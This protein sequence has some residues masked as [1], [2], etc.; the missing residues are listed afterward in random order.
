MNPR[1]SSS[2]AR[3]R[4]HILPVGTWPIRQ[5]LP[6]ATFRS[7]HAHLLSAERHRRSDSGAAVRRT[8]DGE[9]GFALGRGLGCACSSGSKTG[10]G[11]RAALGRVVDRAFAALR[12]A[13]LVAGHLRCPGRT[14][15]PEPDN[16][17]RRMGAVLP[18]LAEASAVSPKP[19]SG[20]GGMGDRPKSRDLSCALNGELLW[21]EDEPDRLGRSSC[22]PQGR[23]TCALGLRPILGARSPKSKEM[24]KIE[25]D[26]LVG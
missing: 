7:R 14:L 12:A 24:G 8:R 20:F 17:G 21:A 2:P 19:R 13:G 18:R 6:R 16:L 9:L 3:L 4:W 10:Y 26:S 11:F 1:K 15:Q 5:E 23:R 22:D 25:F